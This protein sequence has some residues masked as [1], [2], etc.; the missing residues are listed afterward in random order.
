MS[1]LA[2]IAP[3]N[4]ALS[5]TTD[6]MPERAARIARHR[7]ETEDALAEIRLDASLSDRERSR[8]ITEILARANSRVLALSSI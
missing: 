4:A 1:A 7:A 3:R 2:P 6:A 5:F 8:R